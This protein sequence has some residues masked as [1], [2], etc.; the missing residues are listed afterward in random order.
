MKL[1]FQAIDSN[2]RVVRGVL[3]AEDDVKN[4][5]QETISCEEISACPY[6]RKNQ[7]QETISCEEISACP[8]FRGSA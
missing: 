4:Q 2:G 8:Y 5:G 7:G 1:R 3:R 6:F